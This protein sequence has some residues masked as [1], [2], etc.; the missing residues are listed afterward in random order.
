MYKFAFASA[1]VLAASFS[2]ADSVSVS[3][4]EVEVSAAAVGDGAPEGTSY[5]FFATTDGDILS[6]NS[7][8][9]TTDG[10][11][12]PY[13][14]GT[15]GS[16]TELNPAL[17]GAFPRLSA[18][19]YITTPGDTATAGDANFDALPSAGNA[20]WFDSS[21]DG[22]QNNFLFGQVTLPTGITG[23]IT[24][25]VSIAGATGV[26]DQPFSLALGGTI[27]PEPTTAL[28]AGLG[29]VGFAARR[30]G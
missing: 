21:D 16:D 22:A 8:V 15:F 7:V 27:I 30:R 28:L 18:D 13:N 12:L 24:G 4:A 23:Q 14:E 19:S 9:L 5:Q 17:V 25:V 3:L 11:A 6:I 2:Y 20:T 1:L 29:L 10:G 26:F